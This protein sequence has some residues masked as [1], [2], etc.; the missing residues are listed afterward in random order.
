LGGDEFMSARHDIANAV[1]AYRERRISL[2]QF[3]DQ[4]RGIAQAIFDHSKDVEDVVIAI[5]NLL[6]EYRVQFLDINGLSAGLANA[7][8]PFAGESEKTS[9]LPEQ[10]VPPI[11]NAALAVGGTLIVSSRNYASDDWQ[12]N[13]TGGNHGRMPAVPEPGNNARATFTPLAA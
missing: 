5:D 7:L 4:F 6:T 2:D 11:G 10:I 8:L 3:E 1:E 13:W 12:P 9:E